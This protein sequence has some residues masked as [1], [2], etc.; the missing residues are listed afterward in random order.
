MSA[1]RKRT[2]R[3]MFL[4]K[5]QSNVVIEAMIPLQLVSSYPK[6]SDVDVAKLAWR[7]TLYGQ[8]NWIE[9]NSDFGKKKLQIM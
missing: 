4:N 7:D 9:Y 8:F 6:Q 2:M 5:R 3:D 1:K